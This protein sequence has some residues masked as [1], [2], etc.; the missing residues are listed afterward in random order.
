MAD[1]PDDSSLGGYAASGAPVSVVA[2]YDVGSFGVSHDPKIV[3]S[4]RLHIRDK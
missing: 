3:P 2:E 4:D 1:W